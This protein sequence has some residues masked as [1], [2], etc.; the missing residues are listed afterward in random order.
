MREMQMKNGERGLK[1]NLNKVYE[2][3][4]GAWNGNGIA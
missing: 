1:T 3:K 4:F 2:S